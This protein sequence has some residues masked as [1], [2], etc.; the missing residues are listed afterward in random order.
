[1]AVI[2]ALMACMCLSALLGVIKCMWSWTRQRVKQRNGYFF[3]VLFQV[4]S[5]YKLALLA[6]RWALWCEC[7][8]SMDNMMMRGGVSFREKV[9]LESVCQGDSGLLSQD[10]RRHLGYS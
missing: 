7:L 6:A 5:V 9:V 8:P 4:F 10:P 1:M 2:C 3:L